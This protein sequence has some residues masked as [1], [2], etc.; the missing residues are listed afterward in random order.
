MGVVAASYTTS[1]KLGLITK[2]KCFTSRCCYTI[3]LQLSTWFGELAHVGSAMGTD[4]PDVKFA[5]SALEMC[6]R[7]LTIKFPECPHICQIE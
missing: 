3:L 5:V 2:Q 7:G 4:R 1:R 6:I